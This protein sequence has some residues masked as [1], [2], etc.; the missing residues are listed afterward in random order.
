MKHQTSQHGVAFACSADDAG[1]LAQ[2]GCLRCY[3]C[4]RSIDLLTS[5]RL[6]RFLGFPMYT[7]SDITRAAS[8]ALSGLA[9]RTCRSFG[10]PRAQAACN[11][12][13]G[14]EDD[15]MMGKSW[16]SRSVAHFARH[17]SFEAAQSVS[18]YMSPSLDSLVT[19]VMH[20]ECFCSNVLR[21]ARRDAIWSRLG[22]ALLASFCVSPVVE[23]DHDGRRVNFQRSG[24][25]A[26]MLFDGPP[27]SYMHS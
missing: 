23:R 17:A 26:Q 4:C 24:L 5:A 6:S 13:N 10:R 3:I 2:L 20:G 19:A 14:A 21:L 1:V 8:A 7:S 25:A 12:V 22:S 27:Y 9:K 16:S 11:G 18:M 15:G